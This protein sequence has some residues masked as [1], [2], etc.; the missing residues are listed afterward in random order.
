[1]NANG[2]RQAGK[3][4]GALLLWLL[5][6]GAN[7]HVSAWLAHD[8]L[9]L[10]QGSALAEAVSFFF[11]DTVKILLL[12]GIMVYGVAFARAGLQIERIRERL[13][14]A[15]R[16]LGYLLGAAFGA[17]TPFCSCSSIPLFVGFTT[18]GIPLGITMSFLIASPMINEVAVV[19]LGGVLGWP[20]AVAYV[21]VGL[22]AGMAGG[23]VMDAVGAERWLQPLAAPQGGLTEIRPVRALTLP[24]RITLEGRHRFALAETRS[25]FR[26]VAPWVVIGVGLGALLHGFVPEEWVA[27]HLGAG[28]WWT[29]PLAVVAGVP[30]YANVTGI[31]PILESLLLK[32]VPAGTALA[33][34]MSAVAVSLPELLMLRQVMRW[35]L[36]ALF[37]GVLAVFCTLAGWFFNAVFPLMKGTL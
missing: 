29:V 9:G 25:V 35:R 16:G 36:L 27:R 8:A 22:L 10:A 6:Y 19:L 14:G 15:K 28:Q 5:L 17:A 31:V 32:G 13:A 20:F 37:V 33:F 3:G 1:M 18:G 30:L 2:W 11:Y 26:K 23:A 4:G 34:C 12:L 24:A 7:P 21:A